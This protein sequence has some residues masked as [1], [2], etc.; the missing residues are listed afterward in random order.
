MPYYRGTALCQGAVCIGP[1]AAEQIRALAHAADVR[2]AVAFYL[3]AAPARDD[4]VYF[5]IER[6]RVPVGQIMLHDIDWQ[7][8]E[9]LVGSHLF[10][11]EDRGHGIGSAALTLLQRYVITT[12]LNRLFIITSHDN[13][14]SQRVALTC[15]F[16]QRGP[17][18][19]D[20]EHLLVFGWDVP[21]RSARPS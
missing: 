5:V 17:A 1:P 15:G 19:E 16:Q 8:G 18:R 12:P 7:S 14:A 13:P 20:P 9:S 10:Q 3:S 2:D 4:M 11:T 21:Q 6:Q